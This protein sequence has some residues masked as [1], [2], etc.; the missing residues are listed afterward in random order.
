M[1]SAAAPGGAQ[2]IDPKLWVTNG[3]VDAVARD[4]NTVYIG[5]GFTQVGPVTGSGVPI[6]AATGAVVAGFPLVAG[7]V[8]AVAPDGSGGWYI[9]GAFASVGGLPRANLAHIRANLSVGSW[10]P[11]TN[12]EIRALAVRGSR[13]Y[14]GGYFTLIGGQARRYLAAVDTGG[15]VTTWNPD[16]NG[17]VITVAVGGPTVYVGGG[18]TQIGSQLRY[19]IAAVDSANGLATSWDA[20]TNPGGNVLS[21]ALAGST[22]YAAGGFTSIGGQ[23]RNRIA[24][25]DTTTGHATGWNPDADNA[26]YSLA[27]SATTVYA[28]GGF[29]TI[30]GQTRIYLAALDRGNGLATGWNPSPNNVVFSLALNGSTVYAGG[31][32]VSIG[33]ASRNGLAALDAGSG[34]ATSWNPSANGVVLALGLSG[35]TVFAG[36]SFTGVGGVV[37]NNL[38]ALDAIT[39]VATAWNPGANGYVESITVR[40]STV[41]A[42]GLFTNIGGQPRNYL[43]AIDAAGGA[44]GSWN[45]NANGP[46]EYLTTSGSTVYAGGLFTAIGVQPRNYIAAIDA[47]SGDATGWDPNA[48]GE[49][50][51]IAVSGNTVFAGGDFRGIGGQV[52]NHIAALDAASGAAT[53]WNADASDRVFAL[54]TGG[55]TLY[56]CGNFTSIG[57][58]VRNYIAALDTSAGAVTAWNPNA[59]TYVLAM[60]LRGSTLYAG[61]YFSSIGGAARMR[62]A[63]LDTATG[64]ARDWKPD[65]SVGVFAIDASGS[66]VY[67][68]G[69]LSSVGGQPR[70]GIA[71]IAAVPDIQ[72]VQ[73]ASGGNSGP[74]TMTIAG[75]NLGPGATVRLVRSGQPDLVGTGVVAAADGSQLTASF[76]LAGAAVGA[77]D[78]GVVN[79][80]AQVATLPAG[81]TIATTEAPQLR[82][83]IIG[84]PLIRAN[85]RNAYDFVLENPGNV[86][87][88]DV[89]L[90]ITGVPTEDTLALDFPLAAPPRSGGEPDWTTVPLYFTSPGGRYV[91]LVIPRVPPGISVRRIFLTHPGTVPSF[92]LRAAITPPWVD[93]AVFRGCL[94]NAGI[95]AP[96]CMGAQLTAI[97]AFLAGNPQLQALSGIGVWAKIAWQCEGAT[98][99]PAALAKAEQ[100]LDGMVQAIEQPSS[101]VAACSNVLPP[102]WRDSLLVTVVTSFDPN[103]KLGA[104]GTLPLGAPVSYSIRFEN[105]STA[106]AP[107]QQAL[108]SDALETTKLDPTTVTFEDITIGNLRIHVPSVRS[109][110]TRVDLRPTHDLFVDVSGE[111]D[112][113]TGVVT[114]YFNSID[115][116]T[117][118]RPA[119]PLSGFLPQ[120]NAQHEGEASVLFNV[121]PLPTLG[122]GIPV[123]NRASITFDTNTP[124]WTPY[125]TN[126]FEESPPASHVLPLPTNSD[127]PSVL[128]QWTV[129]GSPPDL[130]DFTIYV[131]EDGAPYRV[132]R[133]NTAATADTLV[134]PADHKIHHYAFYSE[135]RDV[136]GSSEAPPSAPDATTQSRTAVGQPGPWRLAL[137][138]ARPNPAFDALRVWFTL[139]SKE[140]TTLDVIDLAGRRVLRR[141][142]GSLGPGTHSVTLA[143]SPQ[144]RPGIYFLGLKR[145]E[146]VLGVRATLLR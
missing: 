61:G 93:G 71:A 39:G 32:F 20:S 102:R 146:R 64:L 7:Q 138:G 72:S 52:R 141:E 14:V 125:V 137:E 58:Q 23:L 75:H 37:R 17:A 81:F 16:A 128:V 115:P 21:L 3:Q 54:V 112:P 30:G 120:N 5:G 15:V 104:Q 35:T 1:L 107:V 103:D 9:G 124:H 131:A 91:S 2:S 56:A 116:A 97:N 19:S 87:A 4:G 53:G 49:V 108:I 123:S 105:A 42:G 98:T 126:T 121:M 31:A 127:M 69:D 96:A 68:G 44:L 77:W 65:A 59:D 13:V 134:P 90:W 25:I 130:L 38:A 88:L 142:V 133:L 62:I 82:V 143:D 45:P 95:S 114:W 67:V 43:A 6:D 122:P 144:L 74:V 99:L 86:D 145:G 10:N 55:T 57:G 136:T 79:P 33:E 50:F 76:D 27:V 24:A 118:Q 109:F 85:V 8:K 113:F 36:G 111:T 73:P 28:V 117:G 119:D 47:A 106:T 94:A 139:T 46:V 70:T 22:V 135:A 41:Y 66:Q 80:D 83:H 84:P 48:D 26:V 110:S 60:G 101:T 78:V 92:H 40:G 129:E 132:W 12:D 51:A 63:A 89:P 34:L 140:P 18:F 11:G 100:V 29:G